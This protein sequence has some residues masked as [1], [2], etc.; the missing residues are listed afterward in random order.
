MAAEGRDVLQKHKGAAESLLMLVRRNGG[1]AAVNLAERPLPAR[2]ASGCRP[3]VRRTRCVVQNA[4]L[5]AGRPSQKECSQG[6]A[7]PPVPAGRALCC[8]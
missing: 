6:D 3:G 7:C 1:G 5:P 2:P 8:T 4:S